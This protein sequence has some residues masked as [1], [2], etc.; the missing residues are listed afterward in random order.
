M[1]GILFNKRDQYGVAAG[2]CTF[3]IIIAFSICYI[4]YFC[5]SIYALSQ[6]SDK[7]IRK[8]CEDSIL[9]RYV[10]VSI[11]VPF[12]L[13][14]TSKNNEKGNSPCYNLLL[15]CRVSYHDR[16]WLY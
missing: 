6:V 7:T 3:I 16:I 13:G 2:I 1:S 15:V 5:Y 12:A 8:T 4:V 10:L 9:W 11:L 14:N